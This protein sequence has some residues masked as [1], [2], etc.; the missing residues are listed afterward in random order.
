[1][2]NAAETLS[3]PPDAVLGEITAGSLQV[4]LAS[5]EEEL[6]ASQVLRYRVFV[7]ECGAKVSAEMNAV[8]RDWDEFDPVCDHLLVVEHGAQTQQVVG[9]YRLL[10]REGMQ[11]IGRFYSA[12]EF[13]ISRIA[14]HP[15]PIMELGRSCVH[16]NYRNR[17]VMQLLWRGIAAY[18]E[19]YGIEVMFGCAS[20]HGLDLQAHAGALSYLHHYHA[21]PGEL[22]MK[23]LPERYVDM[24]LIAKDEL[25]AKRE[26]ANLPPLVK[27]Y[28]RLGGFVGNGA[29]IDHDYNTVDVGVVVVTQAVS[30]KY[31]NRYASANFREQF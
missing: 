16:E 24:N 20:L 30:G 21:A 31:V 4:K 3:F 12:S 11:K 8:K 6:R 7:D 18:V 27:G 1:M 2:K 22:G 29:V 14:A 25:N 19:H 13:D 15:G 10:R 26:F 5:G 28:L 23:A 9:S 17:A